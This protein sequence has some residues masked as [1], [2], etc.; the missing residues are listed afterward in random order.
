MSCGR[1]SEPPRASAQSSPSAADP[2]KGRALRQLP[3][4]VD[5]LANAPL[6]SPH[7]F[8]TYTD[9]RTSAPW[10]LTPPHAPPHRRR[11]HLAPLRPLSWR[12][13]H[14][15]LRWRRVVYSPPH[16]RQDS[17]MAPLRRSREPGSKDVDGGLAAIAWARG[18]ASPLPPPRVQLRLLRPCSAYLEPAAPT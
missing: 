1:D 15:L 5:R 3:I 18:T 13:G 2:V 9:H 12:K 8:S 11:V 16:L 10:I 17:C 7:G 14:S 4:D 6:Q